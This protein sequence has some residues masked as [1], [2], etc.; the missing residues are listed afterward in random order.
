M[1]AGKALANAAD[2]RILGASSSS[3]KRLV[4]AARV[5]GRSGKVW[6]ACSA[7]SAST[8]AFG[9]L[10]PSASVVHALTRIWSL[11]LV[12]TWWSAT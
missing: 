6:A 11:A 1:S 7:S 3:S 8:R 9:R 12:T 5:A 2:V 10:P 4:S